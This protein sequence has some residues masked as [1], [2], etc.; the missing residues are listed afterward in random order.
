MLF[1]RQL[2]AHKW[3][4]LRHVL[5]Q[6]RVYI[7]IAHLYHPYMCYLIH[8]QN[9]KKITLMSNYCRLK[10]ALIVEY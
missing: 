10:R 8:S 2:R 7:L 9:I 6:M 3:F 4:K 5:M 1:V